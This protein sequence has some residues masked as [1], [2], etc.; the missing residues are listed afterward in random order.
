MRW[1]F[2]VK[3]VTVLRYELMFILPVYYV[4]ITSHCD[5]RVINMTLQ[6]IICTLAGNNTTQPSG[7]VLTCQECR[8]TVSVQLQPTCWR[9]VQVA[10]ASLA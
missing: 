2:S 10:S 6:P 4:H 9:R 1:S 3:R 8:S 7:D 5:S